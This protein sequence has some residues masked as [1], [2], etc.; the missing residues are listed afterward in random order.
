MQLADGLREILGKPEA[1][2]L[3]DHPRDRQKRRQV[4]HH[5][6]RAGAGAAA[7]VGRGKGL[8]QVE[9][10][11]VHP[12]GLHVD[13]AHHGV[14]VGPV[15]VDQ[16][17]L[18]VHDGGDLADVLLEQ[19][20]GVGVGDHDAGG[21]GVHCRRDVLGR[22]DA[23]GIGF[24]G[25]R[26][27]PAEGRAGRVGAVG[28]VGDDDLGA[29]LALAGVVGVEDQHPGELP[30]GAC[31]RLQADGVQPGDLAQQAFEV[32]HQLQGAL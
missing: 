2:A 13:D 14:H 10:Q 12:K 21:V 24:Y 29:P 8:V 19:P 30:L 32:V 11:H 20:Q 7:A 4:V 1:V 6:D 27:E 3:F 23:L 25:H 15:A 9:V 26:L 5:A 28:R 18:G 22:Q 16:P 17:A 31:G